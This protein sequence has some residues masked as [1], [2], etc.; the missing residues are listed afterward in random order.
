MGRSGRG[1]ARRGD[2]R[3]GG[4]PGRGEKR[5]NVLELHLAG[6]NGED[7]G[8]VADRVHPGELAATEQGVRDGR[9]LRAGVTAGEEVVLPSKRCADVE[10]LDDAVVDGDGA[11]L[12]EA[13]QRRLVVEQVLDGLAERGRRRLMRPVRPT[14]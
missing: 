8:E 9:A 4:L 12:E 6:E 13:L 11:V 10:S 5:G 14:P 2:V 7:A 1:R 3:V